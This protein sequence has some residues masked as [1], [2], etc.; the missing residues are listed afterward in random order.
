MSNPLIFISHKH[1]D[2]AIASVISS[3]L[4]EKTLGKIDVFQSSDNRFQW[5]K[6]GDNINE[7]LRKTLWNADALILVYTSADNDWSYCMYEC[8]IATHPGSP[9]TRVIV[10]QCG[11]DVPAP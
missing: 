8:G 3:F 2:S 7:E 6:F 4:R 10:F 11:K 5:P 9:D 1:A